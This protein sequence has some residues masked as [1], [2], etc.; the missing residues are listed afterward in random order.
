MGGLQPAGRSPQTR[1]AA[2]V[3]PQPQPPRGRVT[4]GTAAAGSASSHRARA[5]SSGCRAASRDAGLRCSGN[6]RSARTRRCR[7][8]ADRPEG[9]AVLECS[10][11]MRVL[12]PAKAAIRAGW[13]CAA[14]LGHEGLAEATGLGRART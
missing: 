12:V 11:S 10:H 1:K 2:P 13:D 7:E 8:A 6:A 14:R 5:R 3:A 4:S 9:V